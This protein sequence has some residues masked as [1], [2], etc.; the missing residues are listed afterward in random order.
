[1]ISR[2]GIATSLEVRE[3]VAHYERHIVGAGWT[4][5]TRGLDANRMAVTWF[6]G[7]TTAGAP[8]S[9][10]L[11]A[12]ALSP[13]YVDLDLRVIRVESAVPPARSGL[14]T[15]S[16]AG[17]LGGGGAAA[18]AVP[19]V[20]P[21]M[22]SLLA[23]GL[24][25]Q[26][27]AEAVKAG[28]HPAFP[29]ELLPPSST[30]MAHVAAPHLTIVAEAPRFS[31]SSLPRHIVGLRGK[32][33]RDVWPSRIETGGFIPLQPYVVELCRGDSLARLEFVPRERPGVAI[34]AEVMPAA[35]DANNRCRMPARAGGLPSG[36]DDGI[37]LP[38]L[39]DPPGNTGSG[40]RGGGGGLANRHFRNR[41]V[42]KVALSTVA[43]HYTSQVTAAGWKLEGRVEDSSR[44]VIRFSHVA[45]SGRPVTAF[46]TVATMAS[47][48]GFEASF[49]A[50]WP[51]AR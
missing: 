2:A 28:I 47:N 25:A 30:V 36:R 19:G 17:R 34:R 18:R 7:K 33:W 43:D 39:V 15:P 10:V 46:L 3:V 20:P 48:A 32:G 42:V 31:V 8:V 6:R 38:L 22:L 13:T 50:I 12:T 40:S 51:S 4:V 24:P 35:A 23:S 37:A 21:E 9:A 29:V 27:G 41:L 5:V 1:V 26:R 49:R 16:L 11:V 44:S 14:G 45:A